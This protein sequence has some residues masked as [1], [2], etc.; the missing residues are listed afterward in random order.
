MESLIWV[1]CEMTGLDVQ[2]HHIIEIAVMITDKDLNIIAEGPDI[3][4]HKSK[5]FLDQTMEPWSKEHHEKSGL[6]AKVLSSTIST[7]EA[8]Q[9]ILSFIKHHIPKPRIAPLAG[10]SVG[11]DRA[12]LAK[13]M[14]EV[15]DWCHYRVVDVSSIKELA[16]RWYPSVYEN[17]PIKKYTHRALSDIKESIEELKYYR[18]NVFK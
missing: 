12:F 15:I 10:N 3:I 5:E 8:T 7:Q 11:Y 14:P 13:E 4:I 18:K 9:Q 6:T 2:K 17:A 16:R 1:D